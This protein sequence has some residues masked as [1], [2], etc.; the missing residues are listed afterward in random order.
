MAIYHLNHSY[1][2]WIVIPCERRNDLC[3]CSFSS[4][5]QHSFFFVFFASWFSFRHSRIFK[6]MTWQSIFLLFFFSFF[7]TICLLRTMTHTINGPPSWS[8]FLV[9]GLF[10]LLAFW[11]KGVYTNTVNKKRIMAQKY[12]REMGNFGQRAPRHQSRWFQNI[13]ILGFCLV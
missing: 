10:W 9:W 3:L 2:N 1:L 12:F 13:A 7:F 8:I 6:C 5:S 11:S 4:F